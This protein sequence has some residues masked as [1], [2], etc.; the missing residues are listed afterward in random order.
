MLMFLQ[1]RQGWEVRQSADN[2][3][4]LGACVAGGAG[5][6]SKYYAGSDNT[7]VTITGVKRGN[8]AAAPALGHS[9]GRPN[10]SRPCTRPQEGVT[11]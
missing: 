1:D 2:N 11:R 5:R 7:R 10:P 3:S 8:C 9:W 4:G 6:H